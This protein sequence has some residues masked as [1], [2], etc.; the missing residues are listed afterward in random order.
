[1]STIFGIVQLPLLVLSMGL[2][3]VLIGADTTTRAHIAMHWEEDGPKIEAMSDSYGMSVPDKIDTVV[4]WSRTLGWLGVGL[5]IMVALVIGLVLISRLCGSSRGNEFV[6]VCPCA[7][8]HDVH[9]F[10]LVLSIAVML[11]A[12]WRVSWVQVPLSPCTC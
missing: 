2:A 8:I 6:A 3:I 9:R 5:I 1:M 12:R 10:L 11:T 7:L 4:E